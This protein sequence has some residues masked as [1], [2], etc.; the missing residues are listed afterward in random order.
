MALREW[1]GI[2][3]KG[4]A[5]GAA[6][7]VPGVSGGTIALITGIYERLITA[8]T[9]LDPRALA[10]V[11]G[12]IRAEGRARL[13]ARLVEMDVWF[14]AAL[15]LGVVTALV[16]VSRAVEYAEETFPA[17]L[18]A[19]FFGLIAA[20]AVVLYGEVDVSTPRRAFAGLAGVVLAFVVAG[21]VA[22]A[23]PH[24]LPVVAVAGAV[25]ICA[26]ILPGISGAFI[27]LLLGQYIY[28]TETLSTFVDALLALVTGGDASALVAAGSVVAVFG[29]GAVAGLL[30]IA[31][32][33][34]YA[35]THY[36]AATLTFL[37]SLMVGALRYP[38]EQVLGNVGAWTPAR[39]LPVLAAALVGGVLVVAID[40]YTD[41][42]D[43]ASEVDAGE[44]PAPAAPDGGNR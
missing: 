24:T 32:V 9:E 12:A 19:F 2:Y 29:V 4:I 11:P 36:R 37:V 42:L 30:T 6:D 21:E 18:F 34:K 43:L 13:R 22:G 27:L 44:D 38:A 23:L 25:A 33:V 8:I 16:T 5:M 17:L 39:A 41:D 15:G 14:L 28:L 20:S 31:H 1:V 7:A 35:L 3:L 10:L 26:M 40:R